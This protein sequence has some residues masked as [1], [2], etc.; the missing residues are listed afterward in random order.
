MD[1]YPRG[2][3]SGKAMHGS[4][5]DHRYVDNRGLISGMLNDLYIYIYMA[6]CGNVCHNNYE[7]PM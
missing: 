3:P 6:Y 4:E 5:T 7:H 2:Y 1:S